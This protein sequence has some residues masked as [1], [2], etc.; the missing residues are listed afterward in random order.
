[1]DLKP[2]NLVLVKADAFK[3]RRKIKDRWE[4]KA[5]KVV[6]QIA[7]DIP[8][9]EVMD[10]C[11]Q[12]HILHLNQLLLIMPETSIPLCLGIHQAWDRCTSP[13]SVE[14]TSKGCESRITPQEHGVLLVTQHQAS[15]TSLGQI[16]GKL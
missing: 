13:I 8:S 16:N 3:G 10:H 1:M 9:Y 5:W 2:G 11:G 4:D 7:T 14:P 12:S 15:M 6:H